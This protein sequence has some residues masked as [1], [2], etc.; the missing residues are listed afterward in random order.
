MQDAILIHNSRSQ[1]T[2]V[3]ADLDVGSLEGRLGL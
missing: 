3:R 1:P 2:S